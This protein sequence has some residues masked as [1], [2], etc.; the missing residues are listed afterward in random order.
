MEPSGPLV[1]VTQLLSEAGAAKN[2][3]AYWETVARLLSE[4]AGGAGVEL[5]YRGVNEAGAVTAGGA[6][7]AGV[8]V[9]GRSGGGAGPAPAGPARR[10][11]RPGQSS[12]RPRAHPRRRPPPASRAA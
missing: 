3:R 5:L 1:V 4:R 12:P 7:P 11:G 9:G 2:V 8:P 6:R 10:A